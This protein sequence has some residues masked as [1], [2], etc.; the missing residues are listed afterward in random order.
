MLV[1]CCICGKK[2]E[3]RPAEVNRNEKL[4]R[5]IFCSLSCSGKV[6]IGN[7]P[8]ESKRWDHLPKGSKKD[9]YSSFRWHLRNCKRSNKIFDLTLIDLKDQWNVQ[10][11]I[12]PYGM[13]ACK[14][15][16]F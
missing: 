14:H 7:I 13:V 8:K 5:R 9:E 16:M 15:E 12:C 10:K 11:G 2:F 4:G 3:R 1:E 6:L